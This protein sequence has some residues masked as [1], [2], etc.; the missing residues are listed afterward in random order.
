[1]LSGIHNASKRDSRSGKDFRGSGLFRSK[2][3]CDVLPAKHGIG[4][5]VS[6]CKALLPNRFTK[7]AHAGDEEPRAVALIPPQ[8]VLALIPRTDEYPLA[9]FF[10][11]ND[12]LSGPYV[13]KFSH[14]SLCFVEGLHCFDEMQVSI[15]LHL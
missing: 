13:A 2:R 4:P 8:S 11:V 7:M 9:S 12:V 3:E 10:V 1:M 15:A 5:R 14:T 6:R